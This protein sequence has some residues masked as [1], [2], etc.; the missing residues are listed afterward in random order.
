VISDVFSGSGWSR[1][2]WRVGRLV[3]LAFS[4]AAV[5][6]CYVYSPASGSPAAGTHLLLEL[7]DKGRVGLGDSIGPAAVVVE[8]TAIA[9]SDSAYSLRVS[10]VGY[11]NGQSNNWTGEP[12]VVEKSFV[13]RAMEQRFSKSRTWATATGVGAAAVLF[14]ATRGLLGFGSGSNGSGNPKP[15]PE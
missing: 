5:G 11:L 14:I 4:A 15:K 13:A 9:T 10:K 7:T 1:K 2:R 3:A 8:G 12:L 6:G